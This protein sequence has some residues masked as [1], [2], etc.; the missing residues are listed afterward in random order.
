MAQ[1]IKDPEVVETVLEEGTVL[2]NLRTKFYYSLNNVGYMI[3]QLLDVSEDSQDLLDK[4]MTVYQSED[5]RIKDSLSNFIK[6]LEREQLLIPR[7]D[8]KAAEY[9][10]QKSV[11]P[12]IYSPEK[13]PFVEPELIKHDEPLHDVVL[14]PFDPQLPLA[15]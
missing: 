4:V 8:D 12:G 7:A 1:V 10:H 11:W 5:G 3:W 6:E 14:N 15:E 9:P 2:L 13:M